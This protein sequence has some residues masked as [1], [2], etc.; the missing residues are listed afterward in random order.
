MDI[1]ALKQEQK[2]VIAEI[3]NLA[4]VYQSL[5]ASLKERKKLLKD[6][7][8]GVKRAT[9]TDD[10]L[11]CLYDRYTQCNTRLNELHA[12]RKE[13]AELI[14]NNPVRIYSSDRDFEVR[15]F[16]GC[17]PY[18][19]RLGVLLAHEVGQKRFAELT[20]QA[21]AETA[22]QRKPQP[23]EVDFDKMMRNNYNKYSG[24]I[25]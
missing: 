9:T 8:I 16:R 21:L 11:I 10:L 25:I 5:T 7:G 15:A 2:E 12:R 6:Q 1:K 4:K 20:R 17:D 24:E 18:E 23:A 22:E 13:L 14:P 3:A 19:R